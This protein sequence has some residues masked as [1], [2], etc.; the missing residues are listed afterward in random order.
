VPYA[1]WCLL[2]AAACHLGQLDRHNVRRL[3]AT[4]GPGVDAERFGV[5]GP[6]RVATSVPSSTSKATTALL[7]AAS[8]LVL[9]IVRTMLAPLPRAK[10]TGKMTGKARTATAIAGD[11]DGF[12][13]GS[14]DRRK[15]LAGDGST[16]VASARE[17]SRG[18]DQMWHRHR[19]RDAKQVPQIS[20]GG[21]G[22]RAPRRPMAA[23]QL[24][25]ESEAFVS[26]QLAELYERR[27]GYV[28]VWTWTNLLAHGS[29]QMLRDAY[30]ANEDR[31]VDHEHPWRAARSYLAGEVLH[32]AEQVGSLEQVQREALRPIELELASWMSAESWASREW[33]STIA[34]VLDDYR[35][36]R[37]R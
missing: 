5:F 26:G 29:E 20:A 17:E 7:V 31:S 22:H 19:H 36:V 3:P 30:G 16:D 4:T 13:H 12:G 15:P 37:L 27:D 28:P 34:G 21:T 1:W 6:A 35:R 33:A 25:A 32:L 14:N 24:I 11:R 18:D 8:S 9:G 10:V 2:R 23:S